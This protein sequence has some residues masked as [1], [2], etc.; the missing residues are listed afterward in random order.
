M[1]LLQFMKIYQHFEENDEH[2][3]V[4][5]TAIYA[6]CFGASKRTI[7]MILQAFSSQEV[8]T[9]FFQDTIIEAILQARQEQYKKIVVQGGVTDCFGRFLSTE[10]SNPRSILAQQCHSVELKLLYPV[11][12]LA[13]E[14]QGK[15]DGF[16]ITLWQHDGFD[17]VV[18][19]K[20]QKE[21]WI[22]RLQKVVWE[23]AQELDIHTSLEI[24]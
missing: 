18:K 4:L 19:N 3:Q 21:A 17:F 11:V 20:L 23:Q 1:D 13:Q 14:K 24:K 7:T 10:N 15:S 16:T 12:K 9:L 5:K 8:I 2:K 22:K 6:V